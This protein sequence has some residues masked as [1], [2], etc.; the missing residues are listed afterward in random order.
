MR[1]LEGRQK[2]R[3]KKECKDKIDELD[4]KLL[5]VLQSHKVYPLGECLFHETEIIFISTR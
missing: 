4:T 2:E 1:I 3:S 5:Y